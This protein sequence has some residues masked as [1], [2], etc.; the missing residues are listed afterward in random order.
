MK[1]NERERA[2]E[3]DKCCEHIEL[4]FMNE[5]AL[6]VCTLSL[7]IKRSELVVVNFIKVIIV[8]AIKIMRYENL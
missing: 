3:R 4:H 5:K 2:S 8:D 7:A 6:F 1:I